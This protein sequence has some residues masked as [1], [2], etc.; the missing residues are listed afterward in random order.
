MDLKGLRVSQAVGGDEEHRVF[1]EDSM[2]AEVAG[3]TG[4]GEKVG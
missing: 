2:C 3:T 1:D 4:E